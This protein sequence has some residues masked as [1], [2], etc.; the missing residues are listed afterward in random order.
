[1]FFV[2]SFS[3]GFA[4]G[5]AAPG[6]TA[7]ALA[8]RFFARDSGT[9]DSCVPVSRVATLE[10]VARRVWNRDDRPTPQERAIDGP[11]VNP[12]TAPATAP[13]GPST[14]APDNAPSAALPARSCARASND[15][16]DAAIAA[17]TSRYFIAVPL[18]APRG[19]GTAKIRRHKGDVAAAAARFKKP[20]AGF[21]ARAQL[22]RR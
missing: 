22:L 14:T 6:A 12:I 15:N 7:C 18:S 2:G 3:E 17:A 20:A 10:D 21:P 9:R 4:L 1:M 16:R 19:H 5:G 11:A 13:T 8:P